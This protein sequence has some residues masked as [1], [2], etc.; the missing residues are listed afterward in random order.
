MKPIGVVRADRKVGQAGVMKAGHRIET[1]VA[2][3]SPHNVVNSA[4]V[5][6]AGHRIETDVA[7]LAFGNFKVPGGSNEGGSPH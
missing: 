7:K 6:K 2:S 4:G 3:H 1:P 5:M